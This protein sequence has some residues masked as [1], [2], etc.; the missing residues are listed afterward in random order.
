MK[1]ATLGMFTVGLLVFVVR[2][3]WWWFKSSKGSRKIKDL[4]SF[5]LASVS[6]GLAGACAGGIIGTIIG[7]ARDGIGWAGDQALK[8]GTGSQAVSVS[9]AADYGVLTPFG[10]VI[11]LVVVA[12]TIVWFKSAV[13]PL[14]KEIG[15]GGVSGVGLGPFVGAALMVP[16]V[17]GIGAS[18]IQA[19]FFA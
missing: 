11:M 17:N 6:F 2:I 15:W 7:W 12:I 16:I 10:A 5:A 18:T 1:T 19:W 9:R 13:G 14:K 3:A 8:S 4:A